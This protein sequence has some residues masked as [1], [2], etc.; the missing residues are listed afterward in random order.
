[1][2]LNTATNS[3]NLTTTMNKNNTPLVSIGIPTYNRA[4]GNL[5]KVIERALGQT[6]QN[7]EVIVSDNCSND[8]TSE[9]VKSIEDPRLRYLRQVTNIVPGNNYNFCLSQAKGDYF[10]LFHDDDMIDR[11][12]VETCISS[13]EPGQTVGAF[14]T[15]VRIIDEHDNILETHENRGKGLSPEDFILGWFK[16]IVVLYLCS[17]LYNTE[18]LR[19]VGGF[20][21]KKNLYNDLVPTFALAAKYGWKDIVDIKA[22]FRRHSGNAGSSISIQDWLEESLYL[23]DVMC[24]LLPDSCFLLRKKGNLY[25]CKKMYGYISRGLAVSHSPIDYLR[26]YRSYKYCYSPVE[27]WYDQKLSYRVGRIKRIFTAQD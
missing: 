16:N 24:Q 20:T 19:E 3:A 22:G 26:I 7:V 23:L 17:T 1:V 9:V 2:L 4:G 11:D 12:F 21:S 8:H 13:L 14:F 25:F 18:K 10:L 15:G 27:Y 6:Y 5:R